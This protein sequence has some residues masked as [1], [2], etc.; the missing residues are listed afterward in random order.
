MRVVVP[1]AGL[2]GLFLG[3]TPP[4]QNLTLPPMAPGGSAILASR[5]PSG[6]Q[7]YAFQGTLPPFAAPDLEELVLITYEEPL[8]TYGLLAGQVEEDRSLAPIPTLGATF[9]QSTIDGGGVGPFQVL[10]AL[11]DW[12]AQLRIRARG[13]LS[14][15]ACLEAGGCYRD[16]AGQEAEDCKVPCEVDAPVLA[17]PAPVDM[18]PCPSGW[19]E[20]RDALDVRCAPPPRVAECPRGQVQWIDSPVCA[21]IGAAC[22]VSGWAEV[23]GPARKIY[24]RPGA[25]GGDG[26]EAT[27]FGQLDAA[28][29]IAVD[30]DVILLG[31]GRLELSGPAPITQSIAIVGACPAETT[32]VATGSGFEIYGALFLSGLAI[33]A[34]TPLVVTT[35]A[36]LEVRD[37]ELVGSNV[38]RGISADGPVIAERVKSRGFESFFVNSLVSGPAELRWIDAGGATGPGLVIWGATTIEDSILHDS[39]ASA[40]EGRGLAGALVTIRRTSFERQVGDA[41][42]IQDAA[43]DLEHVLLTDTLPDP[44][45][46]GG[47]GLYLHGGHLRGRA[48]YVTRNASAGFWMFGATG[49]LEDVWIED[50]RS[51]TAINFQGKG[52]PNP[53]GGSVR[54]A[55]LRGVRRGLEVTGGGQFT[56]E[57]FSIQ[58]PVSEYGAYSSANA[59]WRQDG[60]IRRVAITGE[61]R[62]GIQSLGANLTLADVEI[63]PGAR[64]GIDGE[65]GDMDAQRVHL[66]DLVGV[67]TQPALG[68][69]WTGTGRLDVRGFLIER[70]GRAGLSI[71]GEDY[72]F[73]DGIVAECQFGALIPTPRYDSISERVVF[74]GNG[75]TV[76]VAE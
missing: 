63:G 27:P 37:V 32:V 31:P 72:Q 13:R 40:I 14:P 3:C 57:D 44:T 7:L 60:S 47:S 29:A 64:N 23:P 73:T 8:A 19:V 30:G 24:V 48:L 2:W 62:V 74:R 10:E 71:L 5:W 51:A 49:E 4:G 18:C 52:V 15:L 22:P 11:P 54:R 36:R 53:S 56:F 9:H 28:L 1:I 61:V 76:I 42:S 6:H 46:R 50:S 70:A 58:G 65:N 21:P 43:L 59:S 26:T 17:A 34:V 33:E 20:L 69:V 35:G 67:E 66:H 55:R 39:G 41:L 25:I 45:G 68:W 16:P 38:G 12:L 75:S